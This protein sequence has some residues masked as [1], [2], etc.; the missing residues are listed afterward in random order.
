[1]SAVIEKAKEILMQKFTGA[2]FDAV[3]A[4]DIADEGV[5]AVDATQQPPVVSDGAGDA[6]LTISASEEVF[7]QIMD[8][9]INPAAAYAM[10]KLKIEGDLGMAMKLASALT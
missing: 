1:M 10:G 4:F 9:S 8:G 7:N 2:G 6:A 3:V 5:V